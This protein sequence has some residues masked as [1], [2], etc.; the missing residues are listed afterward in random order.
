MFAIVFDNI[1]NLAYSIL[2]NNIS[3]NIHQLFT[4]I[5][6]NYPS[7]AISMTTRD[8]TLAF[9]PIVFQDL[10]TVI[11]YVYIRI[12]TYITG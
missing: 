12:H 9:N 7:T 5:I 10:S 8:A 6:Y 4:N 1:S 11:D 2:I 3:T